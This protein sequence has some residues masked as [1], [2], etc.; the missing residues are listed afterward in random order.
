MVSIY[1]GIIALIVLL[2]SAGL[3]CGAQSIAAFRRYRA[4][5]SSDRWAEFNC[6]VVLGGFS[7]ALISVAL[8]LIGWYL[9]PGMGGMGE[10]V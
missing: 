1:A 2:A 6:A 4:Q 5:T 9:S 7:V 10:G 8:T 3:F